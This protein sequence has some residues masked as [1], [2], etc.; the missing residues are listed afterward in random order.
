MDIEQITIAKLQEFY[1]DRINNFLTIEAFADY[2]HIT[3]K[4][5]YAIV[6]NG[7]LAHEAYCQFIKEFKAGK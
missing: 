2:Y 1:L 3:L 5:A 7:H 6:Q 4:Q